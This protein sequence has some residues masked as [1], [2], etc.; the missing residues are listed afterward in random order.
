MKNL[1]PCS[2]CGRCCQE[3]VCIIGEEMFQ[4]PFTETPCP[5]LEY[6]EGKHWCGFIVNTEPHARA[7]GINW[8]TQDYSFITEWLTRL[9]NFGCG[10]DAEPTA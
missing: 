3:E 5:A 8:P 6:K 4:I 9:M 2:Q 10:C 7:A 1:K